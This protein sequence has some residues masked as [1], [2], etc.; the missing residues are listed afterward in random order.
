MTKYK[1]ELLA[2]IGFLIASIG[3]I[4]SG[5][6]ASMTSQ[7]GLLLFSLHWSDL[8]F[9]ACDLMRY[10]TYVWFRFDLDSHLLDIKPFNGA[11]TMAVA[12]LMGGTLMKVL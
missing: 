3:T 5:L 1:N 4:R 8:L 11:L 12:N 9:H 2:V 7:S 10:Y 6:I